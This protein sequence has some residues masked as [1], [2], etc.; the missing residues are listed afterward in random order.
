MVLRINTNIA[1]VRTI[2]HLNETDRKL[3]ESLERLSTGFRINR[4]ADNPAGLV[5]SEQMRGQIAGLNQ[6]IANSELAT[7]MIQT[8]EGALTEANTALIRIRELALHAANEGATDAKAQE[9]DQIEVAS[10][11]ESI[12]RIASLTRFG[13]R[14]LLDG[15]SGISGEAQGEGLTFISATQRT[16]TSSIIGYPVVITQVPAQAYLRG[17]EPITDRNVKNLSV[18]LFEGGKS[19][20][21]V[22]APEDSPGSFFGRL[23]SAIEQ[24]GLALDVIQMSDGTLLV[25]H[26]EFGGKQTF[27]ASSS[28]SGVLSDRKGVLE[29][30]VA[31]KDVQG[32]LGGEHA[33][34]EGN[35][36]RGLAGNEHTEGLEVS[37]SGPRRRIEDGAADGGMRWERQPR[38]GKAGVVNVTNNA[39]DFQIGPNPGQRV[40]VALPSISPQFLA[41]QVDTDSGFR[42]LGEINVVGAKHAR[43][44]VKLVDSAVDEVTIARGQLGAFAKNGLQSNIA[45]LRVTAENLMAAESAIRDTDMAQELVEY[46][47][48]RIMLDAGTALTAQ[49]NHSP[50]SVIT[51]IR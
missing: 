41:R 21:V 50:A 28:I 19:V 24:N 39:L 22:A 32:T 6:A 46:T 7:T 26:K 17:S 37:Y 23:K 18:S 49:A 15:S 9:A 14:P 47:K 38:T 16:H 34:G 4:G 29:P 51:L 12:G 5:V 33:Q 20:Q 3:A 11:L 45:T 48:R 43:D 30:A 44:A 2:R 42:N 31:G 36:L 13:T 1:A 25:R 8:A 27:Q 40:T 35:L 10:A